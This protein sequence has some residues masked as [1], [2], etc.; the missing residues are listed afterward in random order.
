MG[1]T[2]DYV[3]LAEDVLLLRNVPEPLARRLVMQALVIDDRREAWTRAGERIV[4]SAPDRPGVY[5]FQDDDLKP[6]YVGKAVN[7]RR[8]LRAHFAHTRWKTLPPVMARV[9]HAEWQVVGSELESLLLEAQWIREHRPPGNV[10]VCAPVLDTRAIPASVLADTLLLLPS[11]EQDSIELVVAMTDGRVM[12]QRTR[13]NGADLAVHVPRLWQFARAEPEAE[14]VA[15]SLAPL[16]FSW[17]SQRGAR[18][19]RIALRNVASPRALRQ[20]LETALAHRDLLAE[21]IVVL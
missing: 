2:P 7:L 19:T 12:V 10:Q 14:D 21:R 20:W 11:I 1:T 16:V 9:A 3:R 13:R 15:E 6:I 18:T 8:R 5:L 4:A 17:L